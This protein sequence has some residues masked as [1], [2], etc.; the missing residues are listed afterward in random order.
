MVE[1]ETLLTFVSIIFLVVVELSGRA[2]DTDIERFAESDDDIFYGII[3]DLGF[4][5]I[6]HLINVFVLMVAHFIVAIEFLSTDELIVTLLYLGTL[7]LL[8]I[9]PYIEIDE[10]DV[11][12]EESGE[13]NS[14][15]IHFLMAAGILIEPYI[16]ILLGFIPNSSITEG[17][18]AAVF[19]AVFLFGTSYFLRRVRSEIRTRSVQKVLDDY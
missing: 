18:G 2:E 16:F 4:L 3:P 14:F 12:K 19:F 17:L 11:L 1:I 5:S 6:V 13:L 9:F 8:I 15:N 7:I 10:Y